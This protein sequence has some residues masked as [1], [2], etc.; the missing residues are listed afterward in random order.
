LSAITQKNLGQITFGTG[1]FEARRITG[2]KDG[3]LDAAL[4]EFLA[5]LASRSEI[6]CHFEGIQMIGF[7]ELE[8]SSIRHR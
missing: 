6:L 2:V 5:N 8:T 3:S 4:R 1:G 7:A